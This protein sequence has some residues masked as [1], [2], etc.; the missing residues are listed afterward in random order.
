MVRVI[1]ITLDRTQTCCEAMCLTT[2]DGRK[3]RKPISSAL[4]KI[5]FLKYTPL[6]WVWGCGGVTTNVRVCE[7][8]IGVR[9]FWDWVLSGF[10]VWRRGVVCWCGVEVLA[11][12]YCQDTDVNS[13]TYIETRISFRSQKWQYTLWNNF[14][15]QL[16]RVFSPANSRDKS[17]SLSKYYGI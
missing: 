8:G 17:A 15:I 9:V 11:P 14:S 7:V 5:P 2:W 13:D 1:V 4:P 6:K 16:R 12:L 3:K 10:G